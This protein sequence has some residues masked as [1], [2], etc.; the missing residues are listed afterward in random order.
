MS[1]FKSFAYI[2]PEKKPG[3]RSDHSFNWHYDQTRSFVYKAVPRGAFQEADLDCGIATLLDQDSVS[4]K[5]FFSQ[6]HEH[7]FPVETGMSP[8]WSNEVYEEATLE[9]FA[10]ACDHAHSTFGSTKD[11][12]PTPTRRTG[13][14]GKVE[15][16][17]PAWV[18]LCPNLITF[19]PCRKWA[20][21]VDMIGGVHLLRPVGP[22][23]H[24]NSVYLL[25]RG[26]CSSTAIHIGPARVPGYKSIAFAVPQLAFRITL[27]SANRSTT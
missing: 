22:V 13:E 1:I 5:P 24:P 20:K 7:P 4:E 18:L 3:E 15:Q 2:E 25:R 17:S 23:K 26:T 12:D 27:R 6:K 16:H 21:D 14:A 10:A 8:F 9:G 19:I 11:L